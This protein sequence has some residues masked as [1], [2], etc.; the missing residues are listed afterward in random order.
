MTT[1]CRGSCQSTVCREC[2]TALQLLRDRTKPKPVL[3]FRGLGL[4]SEAF[5][6]TIGFWAPLSYS[7]KKE[8]PKVVMVII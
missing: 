4:H 8:P 7:H 6:L 1:D 2:L 3:W 5:I